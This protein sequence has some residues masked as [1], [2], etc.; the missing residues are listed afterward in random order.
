MAQRS[1]TPL[2]QKFVAEY[3]VDQNATKAAI[4]A[5]YAESGASVEGTRLLKIARI[6]DAVQRHINKELNARGVRV[7]TIINRLDDIAGFDPIELID[8][9]TNRFKNLD[10]IP[11]E[12]R[13]CIKDVTI[14]HELLDS[15][16]VAE[17]T[18]ITFHDRIKANELLGK[19]LK[20]FNEEV[21]V[22]HTHTLESLVAGAPEKD[23]TLSSLSPK[24]EASGDE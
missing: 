17:I 18:K 5:G 10:E 13:R 4:R 16:A 20:M 23:V 6:R 21:E 3:C 22:K 2:Q 11:M 8:S 14:K 15:V 12:V 24:I 19:Y 7:R 1:L 9:R